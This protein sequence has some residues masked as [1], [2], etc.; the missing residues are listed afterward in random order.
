MDFPYQI[1]NASVLPS[2]YAPR[3]LSRSVSFWKN[4]IGTGQWWWQWRGRHSLAVA[5]L[6]SPTSL[7]VCFIQTRIPASL[8]R[9]NQ[10]ILMPLT[11]V[12]KRST[13]L[14]L[15]KACRVPLTRLLLGVVSL[16]WTDALPCLL[17]SFCTESP[18]DKE[19]SRKQRISLGR[20]GHIAS[21]E[22]VVKDWG[23]LT[24]WQVPFELALQ[25]AQ[26]I[27]HKYRERLTDVLLWA[28]F[29]MCL[30]M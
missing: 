21:S 16:S 15:T 2:V 13:W 7:W 27:G 23:T 20:R 14:R 19:S 22:I 4:T 3:V 1:R 28:V 30:F 9:E 17:D 10:I 8:Q 18:R 25:C 5:V 24:A 26:S 6:L 29:E 11:I 12:L